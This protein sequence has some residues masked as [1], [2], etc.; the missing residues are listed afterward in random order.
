MQGVIGF[1]TSV[2]CRGLAGKARVNREGEQGRR[3]G[4]EEGR[5]SGRGGGE[6]EGKFWV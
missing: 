6:A 1:W 5:R 4:R 2:D 3:T